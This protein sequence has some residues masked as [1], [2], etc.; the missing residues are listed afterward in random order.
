MQRHSV[1]LYLHKCTWCSTEHLRKHFE[2][3]FLHHASV[4]TRAVLDCIVFSGCGIYHDS[5]YCNELSQ[6]CL[7]ISR[8]SG[9]ISHFNSFLEL[10]LVRLL[11]SRQQRVCLAG[12]CP[13]R[14]LNVSFQIQSANNNGQARE[15]IV[16]PHSSVD[17]KIMITD[18][19]CLYPFLCGSEEKITYTEIRVALV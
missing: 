7:F 6:C 13:H 11:I 10:Q 3:E 5:R 4:Y 19:T 2:E 1:V 18:E 17:L 14:L 8:V 9:L 16:H 12:R 15:S